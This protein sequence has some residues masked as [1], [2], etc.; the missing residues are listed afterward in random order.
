LIWEAFLS[1][2]LWFISTVFWSNF[3]ILF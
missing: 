2:T 3:S 1:R